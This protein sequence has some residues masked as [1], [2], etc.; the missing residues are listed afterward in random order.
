MS[1][2]LWRCTFKNIRTI[3]YL[4]ETLTGAV[5]GRLVFC[6]LTIEAANTIPKHAKKKGAELDGANESCRVK[7]KRWLI[8]GGWACISRILGML[9]V[10]ISRAW[11][12]YPLAFCDLASNYIH[13]HSWNRPSFC[14]LSSF[15]GD[16]CREF[17]QRVLLVL[18]GTL[19]SYRRHALHEGSYNDVAAFRV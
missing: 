19:I 11:V 13:P 3:I 2:L 7:R 15:L 12:Q 1:K 4:N 17:M 18:H 8:Y 9:V 5:P 10:C 14:S 16:V 6:A